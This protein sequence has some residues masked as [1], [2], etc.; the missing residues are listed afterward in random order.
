MMSKVKSRLFDFVNKKQT[1]VEESKAP[2]QEYKQLSLKRL[3][4][5]SMPRPKKENPH[6]VNGNG[7]IDVKNCFRPKG[8]GQKLAMVVYR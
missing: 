5:L 7:L 8:N 6:L 3:E 4:E 1:E 2:P